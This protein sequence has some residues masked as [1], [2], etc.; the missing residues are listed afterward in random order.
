M[1]NYIIANGQFYEMSNDEFMHYGVK[2]QKWGVRKS[3]SQLNKID[4]RRAESMSSYIRADIKSRN[5]GT[6]IAKAKARGSN[7]VDK[8]VYK[9]KAVDL[10]KKQ[11][12]G[13][14]K[15][16]E[17]ETKKILNQ[18]AKEKYTVTS[19][20]IM[21]STKVG[22]QVAA[23]YF[24]GIIGGAALTSAAVANAGHN[25]KTTYRDKTVYQNEY[26]VKGTKYKVR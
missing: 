21:R 7:S 12:L 20:E 1:S 8:L 5:Y 3:S 13:N 6:K 11:H 19:K 10:Q 16:A 24:G 9:K 17:A 22:E 25:Y 14:V 15:K 26:A 4:K 18:L 23:R 2:G